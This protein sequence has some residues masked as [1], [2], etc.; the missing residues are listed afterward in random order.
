VLVAAARPCAVA[1]ERL[2][3]NAA[4]RDWL[5]GLLAWGRTFVVSYGIDVADDELPTPQQLDG[6]FPRWAREP[7]ETRIHANDVVHICG[8]VL[9][10]HLCRELGLRWILV[11][12]DDG[13]E[14][15]INGDPGDILIFPI[16]ATAK[17][18]GR[19]EFEF[20]EH[21]ISRSIEEVNRI[22][23]G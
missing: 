17:R 5:D 11:R 10:A 8:A 9:G 13:T 18:V 2:E 22:R 12:D 14:L 6:A 4:E 19:G 16:N 21:F 20:F 15:A 23:R 1:E 7:I 3:L